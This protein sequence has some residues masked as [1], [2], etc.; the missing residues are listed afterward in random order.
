[1]VSLNKISLNN[2]LYII[3]GFSAVVFIV[4]MVTGDGPLNFQK[5]VI[6][7]AFLASIF[8][9]TFILMKKLLKDADIISNSIHQMQSGNFDTKVECN[10]S[11]EMK[12]LAGSVSDL[13]NS[14]RDLSTYMDY[15]SRGQL[16]FNSS[17]SSN[18]LLQK[19]DNLKQ[20][21]VKLFSDLKTLKQNSENGKKST[22]GFEGEYKE[23][24]DNLN[25]ASNLT[26]S[27]LKDVAAVLR[28]MADGNFSAKLKGTMSGDYKIIQENIDKLGNKI[29][30]LISSVNSSLANTSNA[31]SE[32]S[33][34]FEQ[35]A[36]GS[37]EQVAQIEN[38]VSAMEEMNNTIS[39][40]TRN[41]TS[42]EVVAR[43]TKE[44]A[45]KG[46]SS[47]QEITKSARITGGTIKNFSTSVCSLSSSCKNIAELATE[48]EDIADQ[49][50]LLAL[51]AAIEAARAG[52]QGRGFA[53]VAD[54]V[55]K[56]AERA[57]KATCEISKT[58]DE[59]QNDVNSSINLMEQSSQEVV[60]GIAKGETAEVTTNGITELAQR[61]LDLISQVAVASEEQSC[62]SDEIIKN[63]ESFSSISHQ[64]VDVISQIS[65]SM[66]LIGNLIL[67]LHNDFSGSKQKSVSRHVGSRRVVEVLSSNNT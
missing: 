46:C 59:I 18:Y 61:V 26:N 12:N 63:L 35:I 62:T 41:C 38:I 44:A 8:L 33:S 51:N 21:L 37:Q 30:H 17:V 28:K 53:V 40:T 23:L 58:I 14:F 43:E 54:E 31:I 16:N 65:S 67:E 3:F 48:I 60:D 11:N 2:K 27:P 10:S 22:N 32:V 20:T 52:D 19:A 45:E 1:M 47:V 5:I 39:E 25:S 34:S 66:E 6:G 4:Y 36:S 7:L 29:N 55:K 24:L 64:N 57:S 42:T 50:N 56:L 49:T 9:P 13:S 15:L